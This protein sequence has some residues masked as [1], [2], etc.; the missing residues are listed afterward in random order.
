[1]KYLLLFLF[2]S[3]LL[4]NELNDEFFARLAKVESGGNPKAWNKKENAI[5]IYQIRPGYFADAQKINKELNKY[6]HKD[7]FDPVVARKVVETYLSKYS[8]KKNW[9][10]Y[11]KCHNGGLFYFKK[12]GIVQKRLNDYYLLFMKK[13]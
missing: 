9:E 3:N 7:C 5:G 13:S 11:A 12:K 2:S 10:N 8:K 6:S 1:M 4:G